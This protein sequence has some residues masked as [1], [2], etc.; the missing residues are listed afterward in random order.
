MVVTGSPS[1]STSSTE[2]EWRRQLDELLTP[3]KHDQI[4]EVA[5]KLLAWM[6][7]GGDANLA[8]AKFKHEYSGKSCLHVLFLVCP[9]DSRY[10]DESAGL[11]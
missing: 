6:I 1:K 7:T 5:R 10:G 9:G 4:R 3:R 11:A 8:F 2:L